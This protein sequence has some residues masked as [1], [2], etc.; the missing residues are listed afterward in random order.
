[1][2]VR[3]GTA[4]A[5]LKEWEMEQRFEDMTATPTTSTDS[6]YR[7]R[8][9]ANQTPSCHQIHPREPMGRPDDKYLEN[10]RVGNMDNWG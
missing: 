7:S 2:V 8:R 5:N 3:D 6:A 4:N 9:F 10:G 1:M